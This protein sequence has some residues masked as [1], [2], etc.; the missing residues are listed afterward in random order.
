LKTLDLE[1]ELRRSNLSDFYS[2]GYL[3]SCVAEINFD[4]DNIN[5]LKLSGEIEE[6]ATLK[7]EVIS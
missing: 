4:K 2:R 7:M 5:E 3:A 1:F 6:E